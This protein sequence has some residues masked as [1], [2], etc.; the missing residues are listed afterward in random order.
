VFLLGFGVDMLGL[1]MEVVEMED[2]DAMEMELGE[3][4]LPEVAC[5]Y[6]Y[7][8]HD[9]ASL[10]VHLEEDD[11]YEPHPVAVTPTPHH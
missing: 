1:G 7:E 3:L 5:P 9:F 6:C 11:P 8:D 10:C 2:D 4:A